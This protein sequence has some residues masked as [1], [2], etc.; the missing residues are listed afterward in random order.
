MLEKHKIN[1]E[2]QEKHL[3]LIGRGD[4]ARNHL[5]EYQTTQKIPAGGELPSVSSACGDTVRSHQQNSG[6]PKKKEA[7]KF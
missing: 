1:F 4:P 3:R 2:E 7:D 6:V 5:N